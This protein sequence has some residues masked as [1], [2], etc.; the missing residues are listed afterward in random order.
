MTQTLCRKGRKIINFTR[1]VEISKQMPVFKS[2]H[3][4]ML[5]FICIILQL[6]V[7]F[8]IIIRCFTLQSA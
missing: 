2:P 3:S 1:L 4:Y 7:I 8:I 6:V 5:M